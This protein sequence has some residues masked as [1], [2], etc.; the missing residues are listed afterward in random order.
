MPN[1]GIG[2]NWVRLGTAASPDRPERKRKLWSTNERRLFRP[3]AKGV[4]AVGIRRTRSWRLERK[5]KIGI[6]EVPEDKG[7]STDRGRYTPDAP[8]AGGR[9]SREETPSARGIDDCKCLYRAAQPS[10]GSN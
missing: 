9:N 1:L 8:R 3:P 10:G 2:T 6:C 5:D 4:E 7:T